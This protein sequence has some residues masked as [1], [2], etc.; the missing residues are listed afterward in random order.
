M[1]KIYIVIASA[2]VLLLVLAGCRINVPNN[3]GV[4][5]STLSPL[6]TSETSSPAAQ[7]FVRD[8]ATLDLV[9]P[10]PSQLCDRVPEPQFSNSSNNSNNI[11]LSGTLYLCW[12]TEDSFD[13]DSGA[14]GHTD[15]FGNMDTTLTDV[16]LGVTR[17]TLDGSIT[18]NLLG[19]NGAYIT[20]SDMETPVIEYCREKTSDPT[21][22]GGILLGVTN[23]VGCVLT[24]EGRLGYIRIESMDQLGTE[25]LEISFVTWNK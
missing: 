15:P 25:S 13:M 2:L 16:E 12:Y 6:S 3:R 24:N 14:L 11:F 10:L 8:T 21:L 5:I 22:G 23:M 19:V 9:T 1:S 18:Y 20:K 17:A 4:P 7:P